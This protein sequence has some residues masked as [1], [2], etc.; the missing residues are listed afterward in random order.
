MTTYPTQSLP[1]AKPEDLAWLSGT[2]RGM[3]DGEPIEE[4]WAEPEAG[5]LMGMFR[6]IKEGRV[7]FYEFMTI[8]READAVTLRIKH[9]NPG[10]IGWEEKE[11]SFTSV[12]TV[13]D[14]TRAVFFSGEGE[15]PLWL[16][17]ERSL[18][19]TLKIFFASGEGPPKAEGTFLFERI[20][21]PEA[22]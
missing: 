8:D 3:K 18:P 9:F 11:Q 22:E 10:L 6:W 17:F 7:F 20:K 1:S 5:A 13:L 16:V 2:W 12:L 14:D 15:K 4:Q 19:G 21:T